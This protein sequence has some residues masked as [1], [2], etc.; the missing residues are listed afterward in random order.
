M[1]TSCV[2]GTEAA[3]I[4][5]LEAVRSTP[6]K[7]ALVLSR[8]I[9]RWRLVATA[10]ATTGRGIATNVALNGRP[11]AVAGSRSSVVA[12]TVGVAT[13]TTPARII[14]SVTSIASISPSVASITS[15]T[16]L[17]AVSSM[18]PSVT[19]ATAVSIASSVA[20]VSSRTIAAVATA[21]ASFI[22]T[23]PVSIGGS[24]RG[25]TARVRVGGGG[26][27][28]I[29]TGGVGARVTATVVSTGCC[30]RREKGEGEEE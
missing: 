18:T 22:S 27:S 17:L 11:I 14:T 2:K 20:A 3:R 15:S 10:A 19:V 9:W 16:S 7:V 23:A 21:T 28:V 4:P 25:C 6:R 1:F 12:S 13:M 5:F 30:G 26:C 24:R 8:V 29:G